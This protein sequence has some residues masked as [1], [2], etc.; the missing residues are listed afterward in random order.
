MKKRFYKNL[1][2]AIVEGLEQIFH[3]SWQA[4]DVVGKL[5]KSNSK[6]GSRD[7]RFIASSIYETVRWYR[8][9]Y[10]IYGKKPATKE[11]WWHILAIS[12]TLEDIELP[13]WE[14]QIGPR[15]GSHIPAYLKSW[16]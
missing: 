8:L 3:Y 5:L 10:E 11:D 14:I 6:W 13:D 15:E 1:V 16:S 2:V 9:Y 4:D 7:R 12:W